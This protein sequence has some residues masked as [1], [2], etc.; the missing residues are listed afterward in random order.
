MRGETEPYALLVAGR[1]RGSHRASWGLTESGASGPSASPYGDP[2]GRVCLAVVGAA[3]MARTI[4]TGT[5]DRAANMDLFA[6][7]LL[8]L[9]HEVLR[10][11]SGQGLVAGEH[12]EV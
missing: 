4:E 5:A 6:R 7:H 2:P 1:M 10:A 12:P 11:G 3:S 9:F 8:Q